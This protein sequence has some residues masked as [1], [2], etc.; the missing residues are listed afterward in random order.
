MTPGLCSRLQ[1]LM[2][3]DVG[4]QGLQLLRIIHSPCLDHVKCTDYGIRA[5]NRSAAIKTEND[6]T[7]VHRE[8]DVPGIRRAGQCVQHPRVRP[9]SRTD[10][11]ADTSVTFAYSARRE[12]HGLLIVPLLK[13]LR[14]CPN[15][16]S[17]KHCRRLSSMLSCSSSTYYI[18]NNKPRSRNTALPTVHLSIRVAR[19]RT[20]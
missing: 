1:G 13:W 10:I 19:P 8:N 11:R 2:T 17:S 12:D 14:R 6:P 18:Y 3:Y 5:T 4:R 16:S 7:Y 20:F 15:L 9:D